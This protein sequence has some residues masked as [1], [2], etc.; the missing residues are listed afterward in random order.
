MKFA[1]RQ[2]IELSASLPCSPLPRFVGV[3]VACLPCRMMLVG[4]EAHLVAVSL[5]L[6]PG[7]D[8]GGSD[9]LRTVGLADWPH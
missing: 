1:N 7:V 9:P 4:F 8:A 3:L 2:L 6:F 5:L